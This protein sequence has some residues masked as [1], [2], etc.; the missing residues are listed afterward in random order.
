MVERISDK[1]EADGPIP[2]TPTRKMI[3]H[4]LI[5]EI[6]DKIIKKYWWIFVILIVLII[7][8]PVVFRSKKTAQV[9]IRGKTFNVELART[10]A[11]QTKGLSGRE[12][13]DIDAGMLFIFPSSD[14]YSFWMKDTKIPLDIIWIDDYKIVEMATLNLP[15]DNNIPNYTPQSK[16]QYVLELN[17]NSEFNVGDEVKIE[18]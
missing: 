2:S 12:S 14:I 15:V 13:L 7:I 10:K 11:E 3:D 17:A 8:S 6:F 18:Y 5:A 1:D 16:A 4:K 9:V